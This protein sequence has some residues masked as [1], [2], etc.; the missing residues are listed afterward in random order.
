MR[1]LLRTVVVDSDPDSRVAVRRILG[2]MPAVAVVGEFPDVRHAIRDGAERQ[3]DVLVLEIPRSQ[4][5]PGEEWSI[6][7]VAEAARAFPDAA[8]LATA[9]SVSADFMI[10][11]IRAGALEF[12]PRPVDRAD[13][14]AAIEKLTRVR[15]DVAPVRSTGR[16]TSVFS[17]KGGLGATTLAINLAVSLAERAPDR[18]LLIE[19]DTRQSDIGT[20]LDLRPSYSVLDAFENI[21][22]LDESFLRGILVKHDSGLWVLPGPSRMERTPLHAE[23]VQAGLEIMRSNFEHVVLD[24][25]HDLDPGTIAGL[26][27]SNTILFLTSLNVSALRSGTA[28]LAAFRQLGIDL[29]KVRVVVMREGT[30]EDVTLKHVR[31]TLG[32]PIFWKTPSEYA[33]VVASIN[34]GRPVVTSAP[35]SKI[36]K[37]IEQLA[38]ALARPAAAADSARGRVG[39]LMRLV[40]TPRGSVGGA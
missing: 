8:I 23:H 34:S 22:R 36:A 4:D 16:I 39:A 25:R 26:E 3:P 17:T 7:V 11:V 1:S 20:F 12:L 37:N 35:R 21:E 33:P 30:G 24:L 18:T 6:G 27:A 10:R 2:A 15:R 14:A 29:G 13:L 28:G 31:E 5:G 19:L 40:W 38:E 9:P 32:L